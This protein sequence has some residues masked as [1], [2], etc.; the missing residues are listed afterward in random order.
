MHVTEEPGLNTL[1]E[2]QLRISER[3]LKEK[4]ETFSRLRETIAGTD[5]RITSLGDQLASAQKDIERLEEEEKTL[6]NLL[7]EHNGKIG[8]LETAAESSAQ[9]N[10]AASA[11]HAAARQ[12][13]ADLADGAP[14]AALTRE[15][16]E[17]LR[18]LERRAGGLN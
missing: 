16:G 2:D 3:T 11:A 8:E 5:E 1:I 12:L 4:N 6:R 17:S 10:A 9:A 14:Q 7:A 18:W 15:A 13:L